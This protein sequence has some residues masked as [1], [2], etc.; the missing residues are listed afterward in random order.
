[1]DTGLHGRRALVTAASKGLG[2]AV[3]EALLAEGCR[4]VVSSSDGPRIEAAAMEMTALGEVHGIA[5]DLAQPDECEELVD[6]AIQRLGG[7]DLLVV[8]T[9][10]PT[11]GTVGE[12]DEARWR[13]A[14]DLILMSAVRLCRA[15]LPE[16]RRSGH[17]SI[18]CITSA[19]TRTPLDNLVLSNALRPAVTGFAKTLSR[20]AAPEVRVNCVAPNTILTDRIRQLHRH[21]AERT[22]LSAED[23]L[24]RAS[25]TIPLQRMGTPAEFAA[26]VVFLLSDAAS[27]ITGVTLTVDG[28]QDRGL[29]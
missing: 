6:R 9:G 4:V 28:G 5:C 18:A 11:P 16:L 12:L 22:G 15:A 7:L 17:G 24:R 3:A 8:N 19:T 14:F 25:E 27:Y 20:E 21:N 10:G 2:R 23:Q 26:A 29:Y 1:M 13:H